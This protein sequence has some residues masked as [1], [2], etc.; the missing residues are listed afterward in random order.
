MA[1]PSDPERAYVSMGNYLF[2]TGVLVE[3]LEEALRD[4]ETDFGGQGC[5]A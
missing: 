3:A 4:G 1:I 5:R 2:N